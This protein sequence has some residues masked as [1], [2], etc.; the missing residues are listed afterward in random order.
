MDKLALE[1]GYDMAQLVVRKGASAVAATQTLER[2]WG[3][4]L[5]KRDWHPGDPGDH[6]I[7]EIGAHEDAVYTALIAGQPQLAADLRQL[8]DEIYEKT[9]GTW[10]GLDPYKVDEPV[11]E[12][13]R[14]AM[15][16][17]ASHPM[18]A[19]LIGQMLATDAAQAHR[20]ASA[21]R[22][23]RPGS[24]VGRAVLHRP[25]TDEDRRAIEFLEHYAFTELDSKFE[26]M[27]AELR[28]QLIGAAVL[29]KNPREVARAMANTTK[30]YNL[31]F[32]TIAITET[33]R[34]E[35][36][37]RLQELVDQGFTHCEG[38]SAHDSRVCDHCKRMIDGKTYKIADIIGQSNYGRKVDAWLPVIPLHPR[39]RCVWL[40]SEGP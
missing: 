18:Q 10:Q 13:K 4:D 5:E 25:V 21:R 6:G 19:Y 29:G 11:E 1:I 31:D 24:N 33:A 8:V 36:Q 40:P 23:G 22:E 34:A 17:L 28:N 12:W 37:G 20:A 32:G 2:H 30:D 39:C 26:E 9:G 38:S 15:L 7:S 35:S 16:N 3:Y 27:K 14:K